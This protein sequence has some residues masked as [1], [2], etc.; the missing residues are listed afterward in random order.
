MNI[1]NATYHDAPAI[2][3]LLDGL[4]YKTS[5]SILVNQLETMFGKDDNQ[6]YVYDL[7]KE[8]LGFVSVHYLPQ[9]AFDGGLMVITYLSADDAGIA[10]ALER[11]VTEQAR[12]KKCERIQV[13][14]LDW[15]TPAHQFYLQQG[16]MEYPKYFTKRLVYAE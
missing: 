12:I 5:H 13:H 15:R 1:R 8:V 3:L 16:Y 6:V 2:K 7:K 10:Q 9:L 4:G 11:Y 14:C